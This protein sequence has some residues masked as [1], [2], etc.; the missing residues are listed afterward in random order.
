MDESNAVVADAVAEQP[1]VAPV[2][3]VAEPVAP[4]PVDGPVVKPAKKKTKAK[5]KVAKKVP[6][7]ADGRG[8]PKLYTGKVETHIVSLLRRYGQTDARKILNAKSGVLKTLR[9]ETLVPKAL[10]ISMPTLNKLSQAHEIVVSRGRRAEGSTVLAK[11]LA[12]LEKKA[13]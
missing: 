2:A 7:K 4:A 12:K 1:V 6:T 8:R 9:D 13:A 10:G 11:T 5:A 3:E